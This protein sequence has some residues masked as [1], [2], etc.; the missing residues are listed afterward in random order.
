M[1]SFKS[2]VLIVAGA[3]SVL[4]IAPLTQSCD[5]TTGQEPHPVSGTYS[6]SGISEL[7]AVARIISELPVS[8][9][10]VKEVWDAVTASSLNGYDEEYPFVNL[11]ENPGSGVGDDLISI[12]TRASYNSPLRDLLPPDFKYERTRAGAEM[13][14]IY[15]PYSEDWDGVSMPTITFDP[16]N[17]AE[18]N[19]AFRRQVSDD[20]SVKVLRLEIDEDYARS[21]PVWVINRND[22]AHAVTPQVLEKI[23]RDTMTTRAVYGSKSLKLKEFKAHRQFDP[24]FSGGSEFFSESLHGGSCF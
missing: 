6:D 19:I 5:E 16:E 14:Q 23:C 2:F 10:N 11:L 4:L 1:K 17:G 8:L 12:S 9:D 13:L 7:E 3:A 15:W 18:S 20:G 21:N 24:W 22:D